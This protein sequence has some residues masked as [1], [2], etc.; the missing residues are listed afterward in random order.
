[1]GGQNTHTSW[2]KSTCYLVQPNFMDWV[3]FN[4][5]LRANG[6]HPRHYLTHIPTPWSNNVSSLLFVALGKA[7]PPNIDCYTPEIWRWPLNFTFDLDPD[8]WPWPW[9]LPLTLTLTFD[10]DLKARY[11]LWNLT[12]TFDLWPWP[13]ILTLQRSRLTYILNI[14]VVGQPVQAG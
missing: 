8:L 4:N 12:L 7:E 2:E 1:M 11:Q 10:L 3:N 5:S 6:Q 14:K 13:T 9:P